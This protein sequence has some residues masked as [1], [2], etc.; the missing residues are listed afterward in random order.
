M[1]RHPLQTINATFQHFLCPLLP[2]QVL[3]KQTSDSKQSM[4]AF[5]QSYMKQNTHSY[6]WWTVCSFHL[7][8][9]TCE[10]CLTLLPKKVTGQFNSFEWQVWKE[11]GLQWLYSN[12]GNYTGNFTNGKFQDNLWMCFS[13]T[14]FAAMLL[15]THK[16]STKLN[17]SWSLTSPQILGYMI[18]DKAILW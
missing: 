17:I 6:E 16:N 2:L 9:R 10:S 1:S 13:D 12:L 15:L 18:T 14:V 5:P 3:P 4:E 8:F 7:P 11:K